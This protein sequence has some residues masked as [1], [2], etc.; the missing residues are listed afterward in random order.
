MAGQNNLLLILNIAPLAF[1][2]KSEMNFE[3]FDIFLLWLNLT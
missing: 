2:C 1:F 3:Y